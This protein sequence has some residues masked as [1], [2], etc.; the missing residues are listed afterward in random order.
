MN[1][2]EELIRKIA[3]E[4]A[5]DEFN[6]LHVDSPEEKW[7]NQSELLKNGYIVDNMHR[8][9]IAVKHMATAFSDGAEWGDPWLANESEINKELIKRGLLPEKEE[10]K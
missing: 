4:M 7:E 5:R 6:S 8:A 9:C 1:K 3:E 2:R 10:Q